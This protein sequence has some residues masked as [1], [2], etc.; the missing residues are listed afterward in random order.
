MFRRLLSCFLFSG[1]NSSVKEKRKCS[2]IEGH[3]IEGCLFCTETHQNED[4]LVF[5][6]RKAANDKIVDKLV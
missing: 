6:C 4:F 3:S 5:K 1:Q 2:K